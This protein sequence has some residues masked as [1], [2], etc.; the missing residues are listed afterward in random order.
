MRQTM[1]LIILSLAASAVL[2]TGILSFLHLKYGGDEPPAPQLAEQETYTVG[3]WEGKLALFETTADFP[4]KLYDVAITAL[5]PEEQQRLRAGI[6]VR[7]DGEL[8]ALLE[9]YTS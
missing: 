2:A 4:V 5:P 1:R 6:P 9:D 8:Q 3:V 7:S